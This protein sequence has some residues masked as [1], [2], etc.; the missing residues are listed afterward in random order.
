MGR[1]RKGMKGFYR[2]LDKE[3]RVAW[4]K[5]PYA[6]EEANKMHD[7]MRDQ[8]LSMHD[9]IRATADQA[10]IEISYGNDQEAEDLMRKGA[11]IFKDSERLS[12]L[13]ET[14]P[15]RKQKKY[16]WTQ[17]YSKF[18]E[19][20]Q[21]KKQ[22]SIN[23]TDGSDP[24]KVQA[25]IEGYGEHYNE[26]DLETI[27]AYVLERA[28]QRERENRYDAWKKGDRTVPDDPERY[29]PLQKD[30]VSKREMKRIDR[31]ANGSESIED[32]LSQGKFPRLEMSQANPIEKSFIKTTDKLLQEDRDN[33]YDQ[34]NKFSASIYARA[35]TH[36]YKG[37][38]SDNGSIRE[39]HKIIR[40]DYEEYKQWQSENPDKS[41]N[42]YFNNQ[43]E[44]S[45]SQYDSSIGSLNEDSEKNEETSADREDRINRD[46]LYD[47][48][49]ETYSR[50]AR[51]GR[52]SIQTVRKRLLYR[53]VSMIPN[54]LN[55]GRARIVS[56]GG[57]LTGV[58]IN[59]KLFNFLIYDNQH[60][61]A[62]YDGV[63]GSSRRY[64]KYKNI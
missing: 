63:P 27:R 24:R 45:G 38:N 53:I 26:N 47:E 21:M 28:S 59:T 32:Y 54:M 5:S 49:E 4:L 14:F 29:T 39:L 3:G 56:R 60:K 35:M 44:K 20:Y 43:K 62:I 12:D 16:D 40:Q 13:Y 11:E 33:K 19:F 57:V 41:M 36:G 52:S 64:Q 9:E 55:M 51:K 25:K 23:D 2:G 48:E 30:Q 10:I 1:K 15:K 22:G 37:I 18:Q 50:R 7:N 6:E 42:D 61:A 46:D 17:R 58:G 31:L 8:I 34:I